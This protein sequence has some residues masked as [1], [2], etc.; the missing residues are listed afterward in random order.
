M[1]TFSDREA[2]TDLDA[3][4]KEERKQAGEK[5]HDAVVNGTIQTLFWSVNHNT[6]Y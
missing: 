6:A 1:F 4:L 5:V 2:V 3:R